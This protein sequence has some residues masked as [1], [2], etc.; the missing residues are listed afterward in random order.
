MKVVYSGVFKHIAGREDDTI[1]IRKST[2]RD[3]LDALEQKYPGF[4]AEAEKKDDLILK[5]GVN[6]AGLRGLDTIL[7]D[8]DTLAFTPIVLGG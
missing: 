5:N 1:S 2:V 7:T 3:V 6:I 4:F 8:R